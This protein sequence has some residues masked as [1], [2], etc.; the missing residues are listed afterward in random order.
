MDS[1][2]PLD[3]IDKTATQKLLLYHYYSLHEPLEQH[4]SQLNHLQ[5][6]E[7]GIKI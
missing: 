6:I 7:V 1:L 2:Q 4:E 5:S 3:H